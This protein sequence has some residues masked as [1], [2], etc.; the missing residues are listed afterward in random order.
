MENIVFCKIQD[1]LK[2]Y[3]LFTT[4]KDNG[5]DGFHL[6]LCDG[7]DSWEGDSKYLRV[8]V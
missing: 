1:L 5:E 6:I 2:N 8:F 7:N 3:Y 4:V